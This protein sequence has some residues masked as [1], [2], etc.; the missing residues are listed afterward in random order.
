MRTNA[1]RK[2]I[3]PTR[4]GPSAASRSG[5]TVSGNIP[6]SAMAALM[7]SVSSGYAIPDLESRIKARLPSVQQR[8]Q[9]QIPQAENEADRL[10]AAV[11]AGTPE[12][13]KAV[14]GQRMGADF[15][16]VRFH[17]GAAAVAKA[18]A[19][20]ARAYTSGADVYFGSGGF[21]PSVAAHELV[22]TAQQGMVS[23]GVAVMST[24]VG[25]VQ[26]DP[27]EKEKKKSK[28]LNPFAK[29]ADW[30]EDKT[31][32]R[33]ERWHEEAMD[34][35]H[36][37]K[38][39]REDGTRA[40]DDMSKAQ[41]ADWKFRNQFAYAH[42]MH[43]KDARIK[44]EMRRLAREKEKARAGEFLE[45]KWA[46]A[47]SRGTLLQDLPKPDLPPGGKPLP[48]TP[49]ARAYEEA[50]KKARESTN[51]T[52]GPKGGA[53]RSGTAKRAE[54]GD[55][56]LNVPEWQLETLDTIRDMHTEEGTT[57]NEVLG[58]ITG[59]GSNAVGFVQS[60][61]GFRDALDNGQYGAA[62]LHGVDLAI[63]TGSTYDSLS[64]VIPDMPGMPDGTMDLIG[65]FRGMVDDGLGMQ[66]AI[67]EGR[68]GDAVF[69]HGLNMGMHGLS[70]YDNA[71]KLIPG[72]PGVPDG[73]G[74]TVNGFAKSTQ[75]F[76]QARQGDVQRREM[77]GIAAD[78]LGGYE[79][80][81]RVNVSDDKLLKHDIAMQGKRAGQ[82]MMAGGI[83]KGVEGLLQFGAGVAELSG[84]GAVA[85]PLLKALSYGAKGATKAATYALY[86]KLKG[87]V[88]KQTID[89]D[90]KDI[91]QHLEEHALPNTEHNR[92]EAK[93]AMMKYVGFDTGFREELLAD[94]TT[95]RARK[96]AAG[97]NSGDADYVRIGNGL[98]GPNKEGVYD[99]GM[100]QKRM[101]VEKSRGDV[102]ASANRGKA[103]GDK[104]RAR[105]AR[106]DAR[107][108]E[109]VETLRA[110]MP[111]NN[112][113]NTATSMGNDK[114]LQK[115]QARQQKALAK[116]EGKL[117]KREA[118]NQ[119]RL[120]M[121]KA[122]AERARVK[123]EAEQQEAA[124]QFAAKEAEAKKKRQR[125]RT[126]RP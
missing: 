106:K 4:D 9:A 109:K 83:G 28:K 105:R 19:M 31:I 78:M 1:E 39:I 29:A 35:L 60:G 5:V 103:M 121:Q 87:D 48:G 56:E 68:Y 10:S 117:A 112:A 57:E 75:G 77:K 13:V 42:Y 110:A 90:G 11:N 95:K 107:L 100:L 67:G 88:T 93:R 123:R 43:S 84:A 116:A 37:L 125:V 20:G 96:I 6:N 80:T 89:I 55:R 114:K 126:K 26:M 44:A 23:S 36:G 59:F 53:V 18:T 92:R 99:A 69:E 54:L 122:K 14:M 97:A 82:I 66:E 52:M 58:H 81:D 79:R 64:G 65:D 62:A 86:D 94:Q 33:A 51:Y 15:S 30:L 124:V 16:G 40:W 41:K 47:E 85:A 61:T 111:M 119:E 113:M 76:R 102:I 2:K 91:D 21:D 98:G 71:S 70:A 3:Q 27:T 108:R 7:G 73:V 12:S 8:M 118:H 25:G 74:D 49:E 50:V 63:N 46:Q 34:E 32:G 104:S 120:D 17:T 38:G 22:H 24:P 101:G 72:M 45:R 115:E